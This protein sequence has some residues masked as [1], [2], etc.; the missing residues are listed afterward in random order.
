MQMSP[1]F[2]FK[3]FTLRLKGYSGSQYFQ[4]FL[5]FRKRKLKYAWTIPSSSSNRTLTSNPKSL[6][7][8]SPYKCWYEKVIKNK[9]M[10]NMYYYTRWKI[11]WQFTHC[12]NIHFTLFYCYA[13]KQI[14]LNSQLWCFPNSPNES[15]EIL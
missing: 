2:Y 3:A 10:I 13:F 11:K 1:V 5:C 15:L 9:Q 14:N 7:L 6:N 12:I 4:C 8:N